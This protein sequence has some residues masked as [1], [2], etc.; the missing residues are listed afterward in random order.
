MKRNVRAQVATIRDPLRKGIEWNWAR[1]DEP[2]DL[3]RG[4]IL[5]GA[6]CSEQLV[7]LLT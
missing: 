6:R 1:G 2:E 4:L 3:A 7:D 5:R